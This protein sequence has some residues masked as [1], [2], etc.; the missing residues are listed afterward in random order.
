[1]YT[2]YCGL[3]IVEELSGIRSSVPDGVLT[4][5]PNLHLHDHE[6]AAVERA[7]ANVAGVPTP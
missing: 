2:P 6:R 7:A 5:G 4:Y 1:M 3:R